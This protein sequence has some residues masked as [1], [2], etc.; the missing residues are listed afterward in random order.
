MVGIETAGSINY[1]LSDKT[2]TITNGKMSVN[3]IVQYDGKLYE[4]EVV[5]N[6][7]ILTFFDLIGRLII[8]K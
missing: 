6:K 3:G 8:F 7:K 5:L 2:G 4:N 1:L